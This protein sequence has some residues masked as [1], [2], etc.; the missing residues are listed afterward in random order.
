MPT[1]ATRIAALLFCVL[2]W[3]GAHAATELQTGADPLAAN[4]PSRQILPAD[5]AFVLS[6]ELAEDGFLIATW[7]L[8][9]GHYLYRHRF[10]FSHQDGALGPPIIPDGEPKTD[11]FFGDVQVYYGE[12]SVRLPILAAAGED[13]EVVIGY[14]GCADFG[15]CYPPEERRFIFPKS[16]R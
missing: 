6:A 7:R 9:G 14:Q 3:L 16:V 1:R 5:Q 2:G 12:V 13:I 15:F 8:A 10:K 11:A 4:Q